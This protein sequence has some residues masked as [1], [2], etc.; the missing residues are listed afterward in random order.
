MARNDTT[1]PVEELSDRQLRNA[2]KKANQ[3]VAAIDGLDPAEV[4]R[5]GQAEQT[6]ARY[7]AAIT[8]AEDAG[9]ELRQRRHR[10][11][12]DRLRL[13]KA[14][15]D[16]KHEPHPA[17]AWLEE[18]RRFSVPE[19]AGETLVADRLTDDD[20]TELQT[21]VKKKRRIAVDVEHAEPL[22][23]DETAAWERILGTAAGDQTCLSA[24]AGRRRP[25]R[26]S[27]S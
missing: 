4:V 16:A 13:G 21:L 27:A 2:I 3:T 12:P 19:L 9:E 18:A 6:L 8:T 24:N 22:T 14:L 15:R 25:T 17:K 7:E 20:T 23:A 10:S 1:A 11:L 5:S 26:S